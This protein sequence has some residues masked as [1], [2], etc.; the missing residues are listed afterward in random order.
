MILGALARKVISFK[1]KL[2]DNERFFLSVFIF[3]NTV[4]ESTFLTDLKDLA[5]C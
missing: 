3:I 5:F 2:F 4:G 1:L